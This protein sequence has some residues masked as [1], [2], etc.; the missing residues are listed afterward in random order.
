[1]IPAFISSIFFLMFFISFVQNKGL[2]LHLTKKM[3]KKDLSTD[4]ESFLK[5]S[6]A[7]WALVLLFNTLIQSG[8]VFYDNNELWAF[9]SSLGWYIYMGLALG[10]QLIYEKLFFISKMDRV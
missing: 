9:Y 10:L 7:Y 5:A 3:Y 4:K 8:L 1:M 2:I 6:D